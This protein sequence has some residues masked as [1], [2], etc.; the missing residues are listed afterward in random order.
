VITRCRGVVYLFIYLW[1]PCQTCFIVEILYFVSIFSFK[2]GKKTGKSIFRTRLF[3][4]S[5]G[6]PFLPPSLQFFRILLSR[7]ENPSLQKKT[8]IFNVLDFLTQEVGTSN[9][10]EERKESIEVAIQCLETA[11]EITSEDRQSLSKVDL[12]SY[13]RVTEQ[14]KTV[15]RLIR[16]HML[17]FFST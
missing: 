11:Y 9:L 3:T 6:T 2:P 1:R 12:L 4:T 17:N 14:V 8:L 5:R 10:S 16:D 7:M 13:I 15:K